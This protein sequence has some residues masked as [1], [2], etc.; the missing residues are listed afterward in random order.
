[1]ILRKISSD[2]VYCLSDKVRSKLFFLKRRTTY[3]ICDFVITIDL[4]VLIAQ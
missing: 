3:I 4:N 1:M 2:Y